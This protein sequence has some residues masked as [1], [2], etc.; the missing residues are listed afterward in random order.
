MNYSRFILSALLVGAVL[1]LLTSYTGAP[2]DLPEQGCYQVCDLSAEHPHCWEHF[3]G[4]PL[5]GGCV[6]R[7]NQQWPLYLCGNYSMKRIR[8]ASLDHRSCDPDNCP[9]PPPS[10]GTVSHRESMCLGPCRG[11]EGTIPHPICYV[12]CGT[13]QSCP[14]E[15]CLSFSSGS[16]LGDRPIDCEFDEI[17]P[18]CT[19]YNADPDYVAC[20]A[21]SP[22]HGL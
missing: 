12:S 7:P 18:G 9:I 3:L 15:K 6:S 21:P 17:S 1:G 8:C 10:H 22:S 13:T 20:E 2:Q 5:N 14:V 11:F 4:S 19:C 16:I